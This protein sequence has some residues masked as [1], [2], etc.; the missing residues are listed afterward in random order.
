MVE[1][2]D[3]YIE[4]D[5]YHEGDCYQEDD[6]Y[7]DDFFYGEEKIEEGACIDSEFCGEDESA[8]AYS[9]SYDGD[10]SQ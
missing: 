3:D 8:F 2:E 5:Y 4:D 10:S 9:T 7:S 6:D 1:E